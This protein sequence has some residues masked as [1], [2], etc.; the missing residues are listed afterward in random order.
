MD[1]FV[2]RCSSARHASH[3][4]GSMVDDCTM[5]DKTVRYILDTVLDEIRVIVAQ[6]TR[7]DALLFQIPRS[8]K[9]Q[10]ILSSGTKILST[11]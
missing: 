1:L 2:N 4:T 10:N 11:P 8:I 6:L 7:V 9:R 5:I 3:L